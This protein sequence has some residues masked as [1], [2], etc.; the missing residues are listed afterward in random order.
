M[1]YTPNPHIYSS[2]MLH[3]NFH[4]ISTDLPI[5]AISPSVFIDFHAIQ[6]LTSSPHAQHS[7]LFVYSHAIFIMHLFHHD[8]KLYSYHINSP[9][10]I[11]RF[12]ATFAAGRVLRIFNTERM[13]YMRFVSVRFSV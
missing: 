11:Y 9:A 5:L 4:I 13:A 2:G 10:F 3:N 6:P 1:N 8:L 7:S 12:A